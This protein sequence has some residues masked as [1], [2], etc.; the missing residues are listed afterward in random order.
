MID[1][2]NSKNEYKKFHSLH[3][4]VTMT[5]RTKTAIIVK[6]DVTFAVQ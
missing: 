3:H 2:K 6:D 5:R 4:L 1:F